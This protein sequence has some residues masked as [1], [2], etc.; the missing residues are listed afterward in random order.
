M[1]QLHSHSMTQSA[2]PIVV[3]D[4]GSQYTQ[5]IARRIRE[6]QVY[7]VIVP[8]SIA[9]EAL[10][11]MGPQAL[12]L[13]GGPSSVYDPAAPACDDRVFKLNI[14]TLG[15][16]YGLQLL[17]YKL[18]GKVEPAARREYGF[19]QLEFDAGS[20]L[21]AGLTSPVRVWN[22]HGDHVAEVP[23]GLR[24]TGRT[25]NAISVIENPQAKMYA[26]EFHPEVRHTEQGREILKR[27]VVNICG[28]RPNW[29]ARSFIE[30][31]VERIREQVGDG[32]ALCALSGGVDSAVAATLVARA[33][34]D[35]LTCVFVNNG[36]LRENEFETV[37]AA[38]RDQVHLKVLAV[39]RSERFLTRLRGVTD[40]EQKR[41][42]IGEEFIRVFEDEAHGLGDVRYLVQG[43]LYPDVIESVSVKGPA[44]TIKSH[45]NVGGL[46]ENMPFTLIEPLRDLFKDEVRRIAAG[47]GLPKE[48]LEKHPFPGPGL[49]VRLL[50]EV[51]RE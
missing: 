15:I 38:L 19:T 40:P 1:T 12:I 50:G 48:M 2:H 29:F 21:L 47:L 36:L 10:V 49:A 37:T 43:T 34:G 51:N 30:E 6:M 46:P 26:V 32:L 11:R 23:P 14:P 22:S 16:C 28:A 35:R 31:A 9:F 7:A 25:E 24:V 45:H 44:A 4:F 41:K 17:S 3:L 39:D 20:E 13:S 8:C 18:G 33:I 42:I 5:L 27:F